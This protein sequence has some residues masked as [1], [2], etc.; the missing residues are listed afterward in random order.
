V[1]L[2]CVLRALPSLRGRFVLRP[3]VLGPLLRFG[4]WS[5][6]TSVVAPLMGQMDR[7]L[8]GALLSVSAVAFYTTPYEVVAKLLVFPVAVGG[9]VFPAFAASYRT[10]PRRAAAIFGR[11]SRA[12]LAVLFPAVVLVVC[13]AR[14]GLELWLGARFA[15][16]STFVAQV[17]AAGFL[18]NGVA[19]MPFTLLQGVRRPHLVALLQVV[20]LPLY[21]GVLW[22]LAH[23]WGIGGVAA[24]WALRAGVDAAVLFALAGRALPEARP[25]LGRIAALAGGALA[26]LALAAQ[27]QAFGA[28]VAAAAA[29]LALGGF[30]GWT[31]GLDP[32]E[33]AWVRA[34]L[35]RRRPLVEPAGD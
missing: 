31:A 18:L 29:A 9:V 1:H 5:T 11:A 16:E 25:L 33:R 34:R 6:V 21:L 3:A 28:R 13:F 35:A 32:E 22:V 14:D 2:A 30:A 10:D 23:R 26:V 7:F 27:P 20:E 15:A 24:A 17:L 19:Q 4:G 8:V 12:V